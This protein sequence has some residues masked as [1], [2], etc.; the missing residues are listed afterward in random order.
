MTGSGDERSIQE[1]EYVT[2]WLMV[3]VG[4]SWVSRLSRA[5]IRGSGCGVALVEAAWV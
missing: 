2:S 1:L 4:P 3:S 5:A